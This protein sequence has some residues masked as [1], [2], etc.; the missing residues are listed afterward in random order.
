MSGHTDV[1]QTHHQPSKTVYCNGLKKKQTMHGSLDITA[2]CVLVWYST[3][4]GEFTSR[5]DKILFGLVL[6]GVTQL[7]EL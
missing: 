2:K 1:H 4:F 3:V 7:V 5:V 6:H